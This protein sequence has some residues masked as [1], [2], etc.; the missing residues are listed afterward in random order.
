MSC[1]VV[2]GNFISGWLDRCAFSHVKGLVLLTGSEVGIGER[3]GGGV[4]VCRRL[5]DFIAQMHR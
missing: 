5:G 4:G 2:G 1:L 3:G